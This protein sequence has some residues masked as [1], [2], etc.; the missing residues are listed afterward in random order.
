MVNA[1]TTRKGQ[2][3]QAP[4]FITTFFDHPLAGLIWL[5]IRVWLG[6]QWI[7]AS[8]HKFESPA[9]VQTGT[10]LKGFWAGAVAI[11]ATGSAPIQY[12]WYRAFIQMMLNTNAYIWF[13][14]LVPVGEFLVGL[15]L[16]LGIFTGF[17]AFVGGFMNW[18]FMMAG[19]A[20]VN[21]MFFAL[22]VLLVMAWKVAGYFGVD[23]FLVPSLGQLWS[24]RKKVAS[25][26]P[27]RIPEGAEASAD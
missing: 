23:Y 1:V 3:I 26:I 22:E 7:S 5:P 2:K 25:T 10:A 12:D 15:T 9:W 4:S 16:I 13:A 19:S 14:K 11:P 27:S 6:W 21:P 24:G 18:N 17:S 20:S 8:L